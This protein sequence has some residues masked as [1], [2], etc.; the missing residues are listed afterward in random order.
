MYSV[1]M[2]PCLETEMKWIPIEEDLPED[3]SD[4][5]VAYENY[6][7]RYVLLGRYAPLRIRHEVTYL[8]WEDC[9]VLEGK[10]THWMPLPPPPDSQ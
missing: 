1:I 7:V 4:V 6:N 3:D 8:W 2:R 9:E 10:V 5:L